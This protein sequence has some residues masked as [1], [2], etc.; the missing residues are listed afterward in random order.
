M[1]K[2]FNDS[3]SALS[4]FGRDKRV[5]T[6][7]A[8]AE[9]VERRPRREESEG[10]H[11]EYRERGAKPF[12]RASY[13]PHFS[14]DNKPLFEGEQGERKSYGDRKPYGERKSFGDRKPYG[15]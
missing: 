2:K 11:N 15:D 4:R 5:R 12:K 1:E 9:R 10:G 13:N 8:A 7:T 3:S 14:A 6:V